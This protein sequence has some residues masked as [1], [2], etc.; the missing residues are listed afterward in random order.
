MPQRAVISLVHLWLSWFS[1]FIRM[2]VILFVC[3]ILLSFS[4]LF[5][6]RYLFQVTIYI[7]LQVRIYIYIFGFALYLTAVRMSCQLFAMFVLFFVKF[8][9]H[10]F[11][12]TNLTKENSLLLFFSTKNKIRIYLFFCQCI[13][14]FVVCFS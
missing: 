1:R 11:S 2:C 12:Y 4:E 3:L 13:C 14:I 10:S 5:I 6:Y 7:Q 9:F 8:L